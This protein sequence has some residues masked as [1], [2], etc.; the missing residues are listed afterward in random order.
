MSIEDL[1][2]F[3]GLTP[4][5]VREWL[6]KLDPSIKPGASMAEDIQAVSDLC[7]ETPQSL[8][9]E[10]NPRMRGPGYPSDAT[11]RTNGHGAWWCASTQTQPLTQRKQRSDR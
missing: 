10:I 9:R 8:L 3:Q 7:G 6:H 11:T 2:E 1:D 4:Q 5:M